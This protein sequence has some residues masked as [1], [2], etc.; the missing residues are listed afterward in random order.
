MSFIGEM[1]EEKYGELEDKY[2]LL[3]ARV[4]EFRHKLK[5]EGSSLVDSSELLEVYDEYFKI[6]TVHAHN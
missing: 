2:N 1:W 5:Q 4:L 3:Q 6:T